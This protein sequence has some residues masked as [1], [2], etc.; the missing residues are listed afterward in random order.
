MYIESLHIQ[1]FG[2][3]KNRDISFDDRINIIEGANESGKS[4]L[5]AFIQFMFYGFSDKGQRRRYYS[6]GSG[7]ASGTMTVVCEGTRYRIE[8]EHIE[9]TGDKVRIIDLES[10][11]PAFEGKKPEEVFLGVS[12]EI[13][14]HTAYIGQTAGGYVGGE[15]LSASIENILFSA[16]ENVDTTKA[17]KRLDDARVVLQH[18]RGKGGRIYELAEE[19]DGLIRRLDAAK[20]ANSGIIEKEGTLRDTKSSIEANEKKLADHKELLEHY[21]NAK[22]YRTYK[23]YRSLKKKAAELEAL[24]DAL[25]AS[26]TYEGFLPDSEYIEKL[27]ALEDE[28]EHLEEAAA[29]LNREIDQQRMRN[30][31]LFEMSLFIDRVNERGGIDEVVGIFK[32]IG[33]RK[34][35][36][37]L[38]SVLGFIFALCTGVATL[39]FY[40]TSEA[41]LVYGGLVTL[42]F[43]LIGLIFVIF[44]SR[45]KI[46]ANE[47]L[48]E[49]DVDSR[50][51]FNEA[52]NRFVADENRLSL[53]NSRV[54]DLEDRYNKILRTK[55][56]KE[57][58]AFSEA[59]RWGK[60]DHMEALRKSKEVLKL[61]E[62]N[63]SSAEKYAL[64]RDA[65]KAEAEVIDPVAVKE[66]LGDRPYTEDVFDMDKVNEALRE[67]DFYTK[68]T[69][70]LKQNAAELEKE[71]AVLY[72]TREDPTILN[73]RVNELSSVISSLTAKLNAYIM[74]HEK[75]CEASEA[76]RS[77]VSPRL[78][79]TAGNLLSRMTDGRY[80]SIG[81]TKELDMKYEAQGQNRDL[82]YMSAG[83]RDLAYYALRLS[84]IRLLY[85]K[86]LPPVIFDESFARLDDRRMD[87][88]FSVVADENMQS[89][90]FTSQTRDARRMA[91]LGIRFNHIKL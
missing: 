34:V 33:R 21:E 4:T 12:G 8:R 83:T 1:D 61:L 11:L 48:A 24:N 14:S 9:N 59:Y 62:E 56:E 51:D 80:C 37:T 70:Y 18:K 50:Q 16:D 25:R 76:L 81:V 40:K 65:F 10:N 60:S 78:A 22:A 44:A 64:A 79:E 49:L 26:Y 43:L 20:S 74:A 58:I 38:F 42:C 30:S 52:V 63:K 35:I 3:T 84:L 57:S 19:R 2:G 90:I 47:F 66:A 45:Q 82:E 68:T 85:K 15:K 36:M 69:E 73:D 27:S 17:L 13:F 67:K 53:H 89:L 31:D 46:N 28:I 72:A 54:R 87:N 6:W 32:R 77:G 29:E 75:L 86:Q 71:L 23:K 55:Q 39:L 41:V 5:S 88:F 91:D 7:S